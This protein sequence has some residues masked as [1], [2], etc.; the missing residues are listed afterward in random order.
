MPILKSGFSKDAQQNINE[1]FDI[2][3]ALSSMVFKV[4]LGSCEKG[5]GEGLK[6]LKPVKPYYVSM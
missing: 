3:G 5:K 1:C 4:C 6:P 2:V